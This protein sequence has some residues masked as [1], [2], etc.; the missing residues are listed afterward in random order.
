[1]L[2]QTCPTAEQFSDPDIGLERRAAVRYLCDREVFY[3]PLWTSE[4]H[5]ARIRNVSA[6]GISLLVASPIDPGTD[7]AIDMKTVDP[8]ILLTLV[9][10]VVHATKQEEDSWIIGC[11]F[12]TRLSD[13][14]LRVLL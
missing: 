8:S 9:A 13:E 6:D 2:L 5:W 1:M 10:R 4:R 14:D 12:L 3:F 7:L 11:R